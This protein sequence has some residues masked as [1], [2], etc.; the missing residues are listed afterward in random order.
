MNTKP[1]VLLIEDEQ[2]I[3][4]FLRASLPDENYALIEAGSGLEALSK[5]DGN[6]VD[7]VLVD[8]GLPDIDGLE[9]ISQLRKKSRVPIIVL[10]ARGQE[11]TKI[12][13]LDRGAD[14]YIT[15]PFTIG[16]LLARLRAALRR[17]G[18]ASEPAEVHT[19][20]LGDISVDLEGR[21]VR[22]KGEDVHLTPI[23]FGLLSS[24]LKRAGKVVTHNQLLKEVWGDEYMGETHYVRVYMAQLRA[25]LEDNPARPRFIMTEPGVGYRLKLQ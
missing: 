15:K 18:R 9:V 2:Q 3:R 19:F 14:D 5:F 10:S 21:L 6:E 12:E 1:V 25:K 20:T 16:E 8:L 4:R 22:K 24:L 23:E 7:L 11:Q 13:A 17:A